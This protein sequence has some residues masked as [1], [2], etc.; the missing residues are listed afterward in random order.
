MNA[1]E[2]TDETEVRALVARIGGVIEGEDVGTGIVALLAWMQEI[3]EQ[4]TS[5]MREQMVPHLREL[6]DRLEA[7]DAQK[8]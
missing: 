3:G 8:H 6:A 4:S 1:S 2:F 5:D 7:I